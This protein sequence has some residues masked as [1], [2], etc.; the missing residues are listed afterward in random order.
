MMGK[1]VHEVRREGG[2]VV[3]TSPETGEEVRIPESNW[4]MIDQLQ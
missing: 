3:A 4:A 2:L 1:Q